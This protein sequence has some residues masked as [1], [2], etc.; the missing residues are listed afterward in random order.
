MTNKLGPTGQFPDGKLTP[1]DEGEIQIG[2]T[3]TNEG[4]VI[5]K[6]GKSIEWLAMPPQQ[7]ADFAMLLVAH[8]RQAAKKQGTILTVTVG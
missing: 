3:N 4:S 5:I 1:Q 2:V 6:F 8:A 7:A